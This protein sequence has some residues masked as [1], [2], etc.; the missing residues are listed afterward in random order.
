[1]VK[2][3]QNYRSTD[4]ILEAAYEVIRKNKSRKAKKLFTDQTGG[5]YITLMMCGDERDESGVIASK[6]QYALSQD[7]N[8][9]DFA[10]MYRTHSQSRS[11][12]D[13]LRDSGIPY[14][15]VGGTRFYER[16]EIKDIVAYLRLLVNPA[17]T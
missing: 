3:E 5:D 7:K 15:I 2:L 12:E 16:K 1:M 4:V 14:I 10:V 17:D 8:P 6:I 13:A 11:I 9:S